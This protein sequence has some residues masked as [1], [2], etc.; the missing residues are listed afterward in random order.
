MKTWGILAMMITQHLIAGEA[1][2]PA[3]VVT[4]AIAAAK[5]GDTGAVARCVNM[6][7]VLAYSKTFRSESDVL[8]LLKSI[9]EKGITFRPLH[10]ET[11]NVACVAMH[12]SM[13]LMFEL[14]GV[15]TPEGTIYSITSIE[16]GSEKTK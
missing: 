8:S 11:T 16:G 10:T 3:H 14:K 5:F 13:E 12:G 6:T 15:P 2:S 4:E 7:A 9:P 1:K